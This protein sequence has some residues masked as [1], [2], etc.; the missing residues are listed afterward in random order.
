[1]IQRSEKDQ[2]IGQG[3]SG[4]VFRSRHESGTEI[5]RKV[6]ISGGLAKIV[7]YVFT[8]APNAYS[9]NEAAVRSAVLR[10]RILD[11]LVQFWFGSRLCVA[12]AV[13]YA[14]NEELRA[15]ELRCEFVSANH[16]ALRHPFTPADDAQLRDAVLN[17][18]QPLQA[19]LAEAGIDGLVWQAGR[20]NPVALNNFMCHGRHAEDG[21]RWSWIDLESG[22][23]ALFPLN[24]LDLLRF[25]LP[26]SLH[27][28]CALFDDVDV[29]KLRSYVQTRQGALISELG[30]ERAKK[31][32]ENIDALAL[33]QREWKSLRRYKRSMGYRLSRGDITQQQADWYDGRPLR[34]Y[35]REGV[36]GIRSICRGMIDLLKRVG[37]FLAGVK[38][39]PIL[40]ACWHTIY[41]QQYRAR[42]ARDYVAGRIARWQ[43]RKQLTNAQ[44]DQIREHLDSEE[45]SSYLTDFGVHLAVKPFVKTF[46]LLILPGLF[47]AGV[48]EEITLL[49][50]IALAGSSVR[51]L[52]TLGRLIQS[53]LRGREKPW[54]ALVVGVAPV[55]GNLAY[56]LQ[57]IFSGTHEHAT[58]ARF[59]LYDTFTR[60][61][62]HVPIWGGR[63]TLTEHVFNRCP[64]VI[65]GL[66]AP[67]SFGRK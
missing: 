34:W 53:A 17:I 15:F 63:D 62:R 51:T 58:V 48:I 55:L 61:G 33:S 37:R 20:G 9:W 52:Y 16:V 56:P 49:V 8:G 38:L 28:R 29:P 39:G 13:D 2:L 44:A 40:K 60:L 64:D 31:L 6:F 47:T 21:Y 42:L 66:I 30:L 27:H 22:V 65:L 25:Y 32:N 59:I 14:W 36:R 12:R 4:V 46:E 1:M 67:R 10:R 5:A 41:S 7:Q 26:K 54:I 35:S 24:P 23:P 57:I 3:R 45:A 50:C 18:M 19:H 11:S 43:D